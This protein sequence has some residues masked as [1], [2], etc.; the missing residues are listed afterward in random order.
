MYFI[1]SLKNVK[2]Y[3]K[4]PC[5][6]QRRFGCLINSVFYIFVIQNYLLKSSTK[7]YTHT[8]IY[9]YILCK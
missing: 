1:L 3:K 8:H 5:I 6:F 4:K 2:M 9:V 7:D